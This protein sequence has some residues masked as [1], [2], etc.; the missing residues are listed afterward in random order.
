MV[1][2]PSP[3]LLLPFAA[4]P[5]PDALTILPS[6]A[7]RPTMASQKVDNATETTVTTTVAA[8]NN[9][10]AAADELK[11]PEERYDDD[12]GLAWAYDTISTAILGKGGESD[13]P[14]ESSSEQRQ[15]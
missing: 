14:N 2:L 7:D 13:A 8:N 11:R 4:L 6:H 12:E 15:H 10:L 5:L 3:E 9:T 1:Q